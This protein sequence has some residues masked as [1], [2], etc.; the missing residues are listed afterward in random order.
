MKK[1]VLAVLVSSTIL[2]SFSAVAEGWRVL[3]ILSDKNMKLEPTLALTLSR[4]DPDARNINTATAY[5][6]DFNFN[7]GLI[8]DPK[9]RIRTHLNI[10]RSE[11]AGLEVV[12]YELS[13]RYTVPLGN[14]LSVG[15]GPSL[16][17]FQLDQTNF[18]ESYF[19]VGVA[20]G[21]NYRAGALYAG[22]DLRV[23]NT[24]TERGT[25]YDNVTVGAK[26]GINF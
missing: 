23:H 19:G 6:I 9:N 10:S 2:A 11:K 22:A 26:L 16:A 4:V 18:S 14:G 1:T 25:D 7:C 20:A 3:P 21:V 5:G 24:S 15:A 13:P 17:M 12:A 8:Q